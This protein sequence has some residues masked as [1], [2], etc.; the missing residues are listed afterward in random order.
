[1]TGG[2]RGIG[3]GVADALSDRG[4][5]VVVAAR[6]EDQVR[7]AAARLKANGPALGVVLDLSRPAA[8]TE[9]VAKTLAEFGHVDTLV[10]CH[11]IYDEPPALF[12]ELSDRTFQQ[13]LD[14]NLTS[15]FRCAQAAARAMVS[16]GVADGRIVFIS[17]IVAIAAEPRCV[18]YNAS[19]AALHGLAKG[20]ALD[21]AGYGITCN[22]IAPGW[23]NTPMTAKSLPAEVLDGREPF[24]LSPLGRIGTPADIGHAAAWLVDPNSRYVTGSVVVVDGGQTSSLAM[25]SSYSRPA[26]PVTEG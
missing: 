16:G 1:V 24:E 12:L 8:G 10:C 11:G 3:R 15:S 26:E 6:S 20:I 21:L 7:T 25:P 18:G 14:V 2:S 22:V 19:K 13:T 4:A 5:A 23:V 9:L 17:S